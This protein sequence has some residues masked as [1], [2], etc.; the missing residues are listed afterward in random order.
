MQIVQKPIVDPHER[1]LWMKRTAIV[2]FCLLMAAAFAAPAF[3]VDQIGNPSG[4]VVANPNHT[5]KLGGKSQNA[6]KGL[7]R[8]ETRSGAVQLG[9]GK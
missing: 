8:A 4:Y 7:Q 6:H 5:Q 9:K 3:G 2:L 1:R